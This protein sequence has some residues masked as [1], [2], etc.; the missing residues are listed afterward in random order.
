MANWALVIGINNYSPRMKSL[1]YAQNDAELIRDYFSQEANFEQVYYFADNSPPI[2]APDGSRQD[3]KPTRSNI[4]SFLYDFFEEPKLSAGDNLWFFFGG[5]GLRYQGQDYL[6]PGGANPRLIEETTIALNTVTE[7][8]RRSGA[9]NVI[10]LLDACRNEN[11]L[12]NRST[13]WQKQKGVIT[14]ASCSPEEESYEIPELQQGSFTYALLEALRI[15]GENNCATVERLYSRLQYRVKEINRQYGKPRQ[16]PYAVV[17]PATK[18]HLILL[19]KQATRQDIAQLREDAQDE[20]LDNRLLEAKQL[21]IRVLALSPTDPKVHKAY[22]RIIRKIVQQQTT[23]PPSPGDY[24]PSSREINTPEISTSQKTNTRSSQKAELPENAKDQEV[25]RE[26][27]QPQSFTEDL[28]NGIKLE[29]IAIPGGKFLMGSPEGEGYDDEKPQHAV[30]V[31]PFYMGKYP[32]TQVQYQ[33]VMYKN[34]SDFDFQSLFQSLFRSNERQRPV[35]E[36]SWDDAVEFCQRLSKQTGTE[37]RLPT[38]AEWEYACRAGTTTKYYFGEDITSDLANYNQNIGKT[39]SVGKYPPNA[40]GLYDMHGNVWEWCQDDWHV[41]YKDAPTDGSAW[42]ADNVVTKIL[43]GGSWVNPPG[44]CR[45]A[46][47]LYDDR[48]DDRYTYDGFRVVCGFGR[49]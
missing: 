28:G 6:V 41:N 49:T 45:S 17:E 20:E 24:T 1:K 22:E 19:P 39:I 4:L 47:R 38:E 8:L 33:Q 37:Y 7:R 32:I 25:N 14:I 15:Q 12:G 5:H 3:T 27:N 48:R 2:Q 36:V 43:R 26:E 42:I 18:L 31:P 34:P 40:F 13:G 9:D 16:T 23:S 46:S 29:M 30:T 35:E 21:W 11:D 10:L 44:Y